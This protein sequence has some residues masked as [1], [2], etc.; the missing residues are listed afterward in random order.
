MPWRDRAAC[1]GM[2]QVMVVPRD[3]GRPSKHTLRRLAYAQA[4]C[5]TCPVIRQCGLYADRLAE[6][7]HP[8]V[9]M[10]IA[11]RIPQS[12]ESHSRRRHAS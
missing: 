12:L 6:A 11:G 3:Q 4:V 8:I 9:E 1:R 5:A 2:T 10:V 7:G